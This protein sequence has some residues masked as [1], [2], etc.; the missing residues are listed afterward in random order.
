[1]DT[2]FSGSA[3][4]SADAAKAVRL[5]AITVLI[6]WL[7]LALLVL[8]H[9]RLHG[10]ANLPA[11][12]AD[13]GAHARFLVAAPLFVLAEIACA[14][15]LGS[16]AAHIGRSGLVA[17]PLRAEFNRLVAATRALLQSR[18]V[19]II[20]IVLAYAI[21]LALFAVVRAD[22]IPQWQRLDR[23]VI[24]PSPAG[25]W[26]MLVSLPLLTMLLLGWLWRLGTWAYF[27]L[28]VSGLDLKLV[29]A[30]PDRCGGLAFIGLSLRAFSLVAVAMIVVVAGKVAND[31][32]H[33]DV[34]LYAQRYLIAGSIA[35]VTAM[36]VVPLAA[37]SGVLVREWRRGVLGYGALAAAV[38]R[39]FE[40]KWLGSSGAGPREN[41]LAA[42]DFSAIADLYQSVGNVHQMRFVPLDL[43]S[44]ASF[45][46]LLL[47][48]FLPV[49][50]L[51][52][53]PDQVLAGL[54]SLLF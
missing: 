18:Q 36:F 4:L 46:V 19:A 33:H 16:I 28:R 14:R 25:W 37:F 44:L 27:L 52:I 45:V 48:P 42:P 13:A 29:P 17:A 23:N 5:A 51:S 11:F 40:A 15:Q 2:S 31:A 1:V 53:P 12:A 35:V 6:G 49:L 41:A 30:H 9:D 47:L 38:G 54:K 43:K 8:G 22:E 26:H 24:S 21:I 50:L 3:P 39:Q 7:P 32:F 20:S 10:L 34:T